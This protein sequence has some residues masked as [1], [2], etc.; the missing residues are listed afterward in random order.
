MHRLSP[1]GIAPCAHCVSRNVTDSC[2]FDLVP[3]RRGAR[4]KQGIELSVST[5]SP[6]S[7]TRPSNPFPQLSQHPGSQGVHF[8]PSAMGIH[9]KGYYQSMLPTFDV[10]FPNA[11]VGCPAPCILDGFDIMSDAWYQPQAQPRRGSYEELALDARRRSLDG[12]ARDQRHMDAA[13]ERYYGDRSGKSDGGGG[14]GE[15]GG[16]GGETRQLTMSDLL[17]LV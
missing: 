9:S 8:A 1:G 17:S 3:K 10:A 7:P 11:S 5:S 12:H 16:G 14:G 6:R 4:K 15:A 2:E 13:E